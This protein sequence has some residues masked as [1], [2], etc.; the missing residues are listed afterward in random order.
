MGEEGQEDEF[1]QFLTYAII[2]CDETKAHW[3]MLNGTDS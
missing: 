3:D 2:S 1:I